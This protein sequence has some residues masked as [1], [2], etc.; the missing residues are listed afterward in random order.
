MLVSRQTRE[1]PVI[2]TLLTHRMCGRRKRRNKKE[3]P[4]SY[5]LTTVSCDVDTVSSFSFRFDL[6]FG[7]LLVP[8]I[9]RGIENV[10]FRKAARS[11]RRRS[12][13]R[14][15]NH[16]HFF[17]EREERN[18]TPAPAPA[19]PAA[20]VLA[21]A[22][23]SVMSSSRSRRLLPPLPL[24]T[25]AIPAAR[26]KTVVIVLAMK[27]SNQRLRDRTSERTIPL[28][29]IIRR[30]PEEPTSADVHGFMDSMKTNPNGRNA[31]NYKFVRFDEKFSNPNNEPACQSWNKETGFPTGAKSHRYRAAGIRILRDDGEPLW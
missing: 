28:F 14:G 3:R 5:I 15:V 27:T 29:Q 18:Q 22:T 8:K 26:V 19:T 17:E 25:L 12:E 9:K 1:G 7:S 24:P 30:L 31:V 2:L 20:N 11:C 21:P 13:S 10:I 6:L 23:T 4:S 16:L